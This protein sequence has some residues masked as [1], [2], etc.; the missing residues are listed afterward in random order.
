LTRE[1]VVQVVVMHVPRTGS[2]PNVAV[3]V[4]SFGPKLIPCSVNVPDTVLGMFARVSRLLA[5]ASYVNLNPDRVPTTAETVTTK[6]CFDP[7]PT[8][9]VHKTCVWDTHAV[10]GHREGVPWGF[11]KPAVG[12]ESTFPKFEPIRLTETADVDAWL[13]GS[14]CVMMGAS[15]L[16]P[17]VLVPTVAAIVIC[18]VFF[19]P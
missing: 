15:K 11:P 13:K 1:S 17:S 14:E 2:S 19:G 8:I 5:G 3:G 10:E 4:A 9:P 6:F 12:V 16:K 18:N 7:V